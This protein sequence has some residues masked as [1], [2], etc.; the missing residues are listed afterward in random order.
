MIESLANFILGVMNLIANSILVVIKSIAIVAGSGLGLVIK[1][2]SD[3]MVVFFDAAEKQSGITYKSTSI[4]PLMPISK[5]E[6]M[7]GEPC[8]PPPQEDGGRPRP[9]SPPP[10]LK[11]MRYL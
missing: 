1:A 10:P 4:P 2:L 11:R 7:T 6:R 3:S 5:W 8:P 9:T